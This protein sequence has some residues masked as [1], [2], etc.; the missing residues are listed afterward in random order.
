MKITAASLFL[1]LATILLTFTAITFILAPPTRL[2]SR[3]LLVL[4]EGFA[5]LVFG[6]LAVRRLV[7]IQRK[8][9]A[10]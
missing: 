4:A 1:I 6:A 9:A 10:Y 8:L 7:A 3:D 2:D 5:G